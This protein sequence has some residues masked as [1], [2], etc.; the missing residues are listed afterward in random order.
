MLGEALKKLVAKEDLTVQEAEGAM[1][2]IMSGK[3]TD[4]QIAAFLI[5]LRMK[6]ETVEEITG[7]ARAMISNALPFELSANEDGTPCYAID[8]C[9]TGGD[10]GRTFNVSTA[11]ALVAAASGVKVAKHGNRTVS[12]KSGSADV[13]KELGFN[14]IMEISSSQACFELTGMAFLFAQKYHVAMKNAAPVRSELALRTIFNILGPLTNPA[15]IKGQV[16][17]VFDGAL[18]HTLAEV[19]LRLGRERAMVV[20]GLDGL[21]EITTTGDTLVS[22]LKDGKITDY[23]IN[24]E[25]FGLPLSSMKDL[26]GGEPRENAEIIINILKGEKGP[27]RDLV[28]INTAAALYTA[29]VVTGVKE[30]VSAAEELIDSGRAFKKYLELLEFNRRVT[31]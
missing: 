16:L 19:L 18:T 30:G 4:A 25:K 14:I 12:G 13:L 23:T 7:C 22:E 5:A 6:G 11:V 10:G 8:T 1:M 31:A 28:V 9:G 21:D 24:P 17:G 2:D 20:H 3:S 29:K 27:K 26:R 15:N